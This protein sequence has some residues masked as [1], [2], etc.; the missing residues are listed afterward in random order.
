MKITEGKKSG[1]KHK[2]NT[3]KMEDAYIF[4]QE[5]KK[6]QFTNKAPKMANSRQHYEKFRNKGMKYYSPCVH[7]TRIQAQS[8]EKT[9]RQLNC[10]KLLDH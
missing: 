5:K 3:Q 6:N 10:Q 9:R 7:H 8:P 4:I 2:C 1:K